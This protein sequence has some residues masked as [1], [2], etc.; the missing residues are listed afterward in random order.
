MVC[1]LFDGSEINQKRSRNQVFLLLKRLGIG[2]PDEATF[3]FFSSKANQ[4][5]FWYVFG[6]A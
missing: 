2:I 5:V 4:T 3:Y 6:K 1:T